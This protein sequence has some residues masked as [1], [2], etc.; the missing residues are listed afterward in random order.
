M[1]S[2]IL[3]AS[4]LA[5]CPLQVAGFGVPE[6]LSSISHIHHGAPPP[7]RLPTTILTSSDTALD[8]LSLPSN[9]YIAYKQALI[10][11]PLA[12]KMTTG[13]LLA[14]LG[15]A[16]AQQC[17][18][19]ECPIYDSKRAISFAAFDA[20]YRAVQHAIYPP[21][22]SFFQG[23]YLSSVLS[24][25]TSRLA[26]GSIT[27]KTTFVVAN[28]TPILAA[29]EQ[30]LFSQLVIIPLFYYPVFYAVTGAVQG[31]TV[32]E[33]MQRARETFVPLMKRNLLFWI[34]IQFAVFGFCEEPLQIPILTLCGLIWTFILSFVAGSVQKAETTEP[35]V[36]ATTN[37]ETVVVEEVFDTY[38]VTG[39]EPQCLIDPDDLFH[40]PHHAEI[41]H[42]EESEE[43]IQKQ[44]ESVE[45][46]N[47]VV[48]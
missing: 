24:T 21:M 9:L 25:I 23:Q 14:I 38:C 35:V 1:L 26:V 4:L 29:V 2:M 5:A 47:P 10:T 44:A 8:A 12:T 3:Y 27:A 37:G 28:H 17:V 15:D 42:L 33:T 39:M 43:I 31:L 34:P 7:W 36:M 22:I 16:I 13:A 46:D 30:S 41:V 32:D 20:S 18:G 48:K 40:A 45:D 6:I 11:D 19:D